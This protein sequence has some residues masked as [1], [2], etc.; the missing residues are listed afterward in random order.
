VLSPRPLRH[1]PDF[2][3]EF[4]AIHR[5]HCSSSQ[6]HQ[7][8]ASH[9]R[10]PS[11]T[12]IRSNAVPVQELRH[13]Q[14]GLR[15]PLIPSPLGLSSADTLLHALGQ[16]LLRARLRQRRGQLQLVPLLQLVRFGSGLYPF[17]GVIRAALADT[18]VATARTTT[19]TQMVAPTTTTARETRPTRLLAV[20]AE[21]AAAVAVAPEAAPETRSRLRRPDHV[22]VALI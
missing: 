11:S 18:R 14:P 8:N 15:A 21:V 2:P 17:H 22:D 6:H 7:R 13:Q 10:L 9:K 1:H 3:P 4:F 5:A 19:R 16:P 20:V 12:V